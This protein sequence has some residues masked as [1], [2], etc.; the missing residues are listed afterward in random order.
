MDRL[1]DVARDPRRARQLHDAV[2]SMSDAVLD[3]R[4]LAAARA[5]LLQWLAERVQG[6]DSAARPAPPGAVSGAS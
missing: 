6:H 1:A 3:Y 4:G 5:P 2:A